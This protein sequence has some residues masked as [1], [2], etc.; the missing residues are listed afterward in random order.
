MCFDIGPE[1]K[2]ETVSTPTTEETT[3]TETQ[4]TA[5]PTHD[6]DQLFRVEIKARHLDV[7]MRLLRQ[8]VLAE[9]LANKIRP[10]PNPLEGIVE[11]MEISSAS[12]ALSEGVNAQGWLEWVKAETA[13]RQ[14]AA[15]EQAAKEDG[16]T[17]MQRISQLAKAFGSP[18][19]F[20]G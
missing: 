20:G 4:G 7:L 17:D 10:N 13:R 18:F 11:A 6:Q 8:G 16:L 1:T 5:P 2:E 12:R 3:S 15:D 14:A 19:G 9:Q